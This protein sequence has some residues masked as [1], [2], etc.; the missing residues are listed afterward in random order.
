MGAKS[1][2]GARLD[3]IRGLRAGLFETN[4]ADQNYAATWSVQVGITCMAG[5]PRPLPGRSPMKSFSSSSSSV[6]QV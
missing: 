5:G 2:L 1:G 3:L 4:K 6:I